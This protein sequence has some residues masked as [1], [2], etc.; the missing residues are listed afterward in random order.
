[1]SSGYKVENAQKEMAVLGS[2][3]DY[4]VAGGEFASEMPIQHGLLMIPQEKLQF[5]CERGIPNPST[6]MLQEQSQTQSESGK[7]YLI[8][9]KSKVKLRKR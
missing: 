1:M 7:P 5:G 3:W 2:R 6:R 9:K 8:L 4:E